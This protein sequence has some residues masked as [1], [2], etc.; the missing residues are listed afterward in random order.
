METKIERTYYSNGKLWSE[1]PYV[2]GKRHGLMK[3]WWESGQQESEQPHVG[4]VPHGVSKWWRPNGQLELE[5]PYVDG[6]RHGMM[7]QWLRSGDIVYFCLYNQSELVA[8][9]YPQNQTQRWKLK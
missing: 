8:K 5:V 1:L 6:E 7:K 4:G 3:W 9:F 2:D